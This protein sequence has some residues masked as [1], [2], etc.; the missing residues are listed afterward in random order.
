MDVKT[1]EKMACIGIEKIDNNNDN[2][3]NKNNQNL[4]K[5]EKK[6]LGGRNKRMIEK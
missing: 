6:S 2:I 3:N 1:S 4:N 5:K